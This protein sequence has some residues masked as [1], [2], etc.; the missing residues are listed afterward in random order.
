MFDQFSRRFEQVLIGVL[1]VATALVVAL[2]TLELLW[3][4]AK[5]LVTPPVILLQVDELLDLF[6]FILIILVGIELMETIKGYLREHVVRL[7]VVLDVALIAIARKI[8]IFEIKEAAPLAPFGIAGIVLALG[9]ARYLVMSGR[10]GRLD[11]PQAKGSAAAQSS[12]CG[13]VRP[14]VDAEEDCGDGRASGEKS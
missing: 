13:E 4:V 12:E 2:A 1:T 10:P 7:E 3:M 9:I 5:D 14:A 11:A 6:G 8:I